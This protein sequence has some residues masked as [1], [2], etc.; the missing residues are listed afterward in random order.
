MMPPPPTL[1]DIIFVLFDANALVAA[2]LS[3]FAKNLVH[4]AFSLLFAFMGVAGI[5]VLLQADFLAIS[6]LLIY[7]GGIMVLLV[8]GVMLTNRISGLDINAGTGRRLPAALVSL[9]V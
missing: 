7:V 5:Y 2:L 1:L 9:S 6:Q 4:A 3:C 8:F